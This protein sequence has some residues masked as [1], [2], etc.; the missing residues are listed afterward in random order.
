MADAIYEVNIKLNAQNFEQELNT[1]KKKL[2]R[3]TKEAKR[4]NEKDPIFKRGRELT[5]LKSIETTRNKLNELDRFGLNT[6]KRRAKLRQAEDLVS[7][8]KFRT[9]KNLVNEAQ[10]LNLKDAENLRLAKERLAEEKKLKR[11]REMQQKLAS[12]RVGSI[13][14]SA[15]IGGGFPLLFGGGITQA[16]PGLIGGA[17]GEAASPGGGFAGSIAATA[18]ASSATQFANSAREVGNALKDPTEGLQKLKD[19]GF[20][21]SESTERQIE[22]LIK[23]GRKTEALEL[24]QKEFAKTIGTLGTDNLKKLDTS[25]DALDDAVAKLVLKFQADLAPAFITIIDLATKF[26]DSVGGFR[27]QNKA[28]ELDPERFRALDRQIRKELSGGIPGKIV[29][30]EELRAEYQRQLTAG[31]KKIIQELMPEFLGN[32]DSTNTDGSGTRD[33]FDVNLEKT[34]L[35]KLVKQTEHYERILEVGFEQAELE[36]QIAEFKESASEAELKK[37]ENGEI[38]IKQL[39]DENR[40]AKQLVENAEKVRD[41]YSSIASTIETG[42]VNAIDGAINGTKTLGDVAR[43]VFSEIQR[44]L[45]RFGVNAFLGGLPGIG[46]FFRAE[47]GPVSRGGS[48]IVGERGPELFTPGSSGMITPNHALGSS[49]T[50][51][52]N[53]DA[54]GSNVEGDEGEGRALGLAL[55]AAIET[56][57]IKQKRPGGLL[58]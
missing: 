9:A 49:T 52:V 28:Q 33:P 7:K 58:A 25:F 50:V 8:G 44:S 31:S 2:E 3:F 14:K 55:S 5:V 48:Y 53:V 1:L 40:E 51:V 12:K 6:D 45:I 10:L 27:I 21:V 29:I 36:K 26:V 13:I 46:G 32:G 34:K 47:G 42:L 19:A 43:S 20:K 15:A 24:V 22:A 11:E 16:I 57:L 4:K 37:I 56:E 54:S 17:L 39:I 35:E 30:D 23:A 18:L 41:L 38:N